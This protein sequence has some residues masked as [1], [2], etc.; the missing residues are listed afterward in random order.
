MKISVND[1]DMLFKKSINVNEL[2]NSLDLKVEKIAIEIN[3][4]I[5]PRS[6]YENY[7]V[8][9]NDVIEIIKAVGGG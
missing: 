9:E 6:E 7:F 1:N 4:T 5:L 3:K 8:K 2:I